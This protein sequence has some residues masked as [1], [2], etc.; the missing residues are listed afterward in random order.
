MPQRVRAE[1]L[2]APGWGEV[3]A[4]VRNPY[5]AIWFCDNQGNL[6]F[7]DAHQPLEKSVLA[8]SFPAKIEILT[9]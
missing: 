8:P 2:A 6:R 7:F 3:P 5:G 9:H 4:T 1:R